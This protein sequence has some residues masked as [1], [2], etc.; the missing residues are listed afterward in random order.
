[1]KNTFQKNDEENIIR[2]LLKT[3]R[4]KR[5]NVQ[6]SKCK[7]TDDLLSKKMQANSGMASFK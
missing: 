7:N 1:M 4:G 3:A 2:K 5:Y 6:R